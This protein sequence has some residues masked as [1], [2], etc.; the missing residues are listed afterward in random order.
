MNDL[1]RPALYEAYH[2]IRPV[3]EPAAGAKRS[4]IDIVGPVC[5]TGDTFATGRPLVPLAPGDLLSIDTAGAYGS[6][7]AS[8]YNS[9]LL[10][11]EVMVN[12]NRHAVIRPR[13][14]YDNLI[15]LD[16]QPDWLA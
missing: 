13:L 16:R 1:I 10:I 2:G 7:M 8:T 4:P 6:V 9:R 11:P 15:G 5:E 3:I 14:G 12:G